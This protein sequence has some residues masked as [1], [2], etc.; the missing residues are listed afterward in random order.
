[1][2][3]TATLESTEV[4]L[5]PGSE[6]VVPIQIRN[7]GTVVEG[8]ELSVIG[9]PGEWAA[10]E[11]PAVSLYP[12]TTT[13]ATITFRPPRSARTVA[14]QQRFG[15]SVLPTEHPELAVVPEGVVE[16]PQAA[17]SATQAAVVT[18]RWRRGRGRGTAFTR[19]SPR[20]RGST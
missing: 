5:D 10:I 16:V 7:N 2:S 19:G 6:A 1:M 20:R 15:V 8:Y 13:T 4:R 14:G 12:G 17:S 9:V 3:T 11:P 18:M